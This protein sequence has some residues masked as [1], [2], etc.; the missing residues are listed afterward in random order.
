MEIINL[1]SP[2]SLE[3][4]GFEDRPHGWVVCVCVWGGEQVLSPLSLVPH[5]PPPLPLHVNVHT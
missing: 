3:I 4:M 5:P 2:Q 1:F